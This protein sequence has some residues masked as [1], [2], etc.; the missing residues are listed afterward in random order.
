MPWLPRERSARSLTAGHRAFFMSATKHELHEYDGRSTPRHWFDW[1]TVINALLKHAEV[2]PSGYKAIRSTSLITSSFVR[3]ICDPIRLAG[4][5][6]N[7]VQ[8][9]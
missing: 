6:R 4:T 1:S 3:T 2:A 5:A 8:H 7:L 9:S